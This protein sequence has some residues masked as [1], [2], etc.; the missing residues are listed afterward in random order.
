MATCNIAASLVEMAQRRPDAV[1]I[2]TTVGRDRGRRWRYAT[3]TYAELDRHSDAIGHALQYFGIARGDRAV[4][5]VRPSAEFF[6]LVF[7]LFKAGIVP[8]MVDPGLGLRQL[9][10]CLDEA[11][12]TAFIGTPAA[13][14]IRNL[15]GWARPTLQ[16]W[17][18]VGQPWLSGGERLRDL[19]QDCPLKGPLLEQTA[20]EETAAI[21]FTSGSTGPAKGVVYQHRHFVNQ[22]TLIR[23]TYG[24]VAGEV[25]LPTFPLFALF[26]P[27]LG[28][29]T[30]V[31][32]M[33]FARPAR[34]DPVML[35]EL[36]A[37]W[38]ITNVF[39]SPA[40]LHTVVQG[41][42]DARW[43]TVRRVLSA[44]APVPAAVLAGMQRILPDGAQVFTP[45]GAT[46]SLPVASMG[47]REV[48]TE[49]RQRTE[50]G[51]G[52]CVG[53]PAP[54]VD[55]RVIAIDDGP[56]ANWRDVEELNN[57]CVGELCV[58]GP[59]TTHAYFG[60]PAATAKA[61][62]D[63]AGT[64]VHRMGDVGW[65]DDQGRLWYCG[66]MSHRVTLAGRVL[67][68][69]PV[70]EILNTHPA[71]RRTALVAVQVGGQTEAAV[72]VELHRPQTM[73]PRQVLAELAQLA[74]GHT[75]TRGIVRFAVH[76][77]F[78]VD[79]RHNAKIGRE[80]LAVWYQRRWGKQ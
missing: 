8:V 11:A 5:A 17:V 68:T 29:T 76:P 33:D 37:D 9:K 10:Q 75:V 22:V 70:E 39:G 80:Q 20:P 18:V 23:E 41:T 54:G 4:L 59:T 55:V 31:P 51:E 57:G 1:A 36:I 43:P 35:G 38:Q 53:R 6:A 19:V 47:S 58:S 27:A 65:R 24:I 26:D 48:L 61:K 14:A 12:P 79:V 45:Y 46:E 66:R 49:T 67:H 7:G 69:A 25:D 28:M 15:L 50:Q 3:Q 63:R 13:H 71:V 72:C 60:R 74:A 64:V 77:R 30:V 16:H 32:P 78:P 62:I 52:V 40:V 21:L 73:A 34:V 56:L 44:G 2:V 42:P